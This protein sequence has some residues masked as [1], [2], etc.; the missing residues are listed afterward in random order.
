MYQIG[1]TFDSPVETLSVLLSGIYSPTWSKTLSIHD[2]DWAPKGAT[3][4]CGRALWLTA[5]PDNVRTITR[6]ERESL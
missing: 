3:A 5:E 4:T 6:H 1:H 2:V